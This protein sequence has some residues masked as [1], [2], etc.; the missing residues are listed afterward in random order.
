M[1]RLLATGVLIIGL[2][3]AAKAIWAADA[4]DAPPAAVAVPTSAP[5]TQPAAKVSDDARH[6]LDQI[7]E[8]YGKLHSLDLAGTIAAELQVEG[9]PPE[10]HTAAFTSSFVAPN[11]FRHE[12]K[13]D[14]LIGSTGT[15]L[16]TFQA[17][18]NAYTQAE[19]PKEKVASKDLPKSFANLLGMQDPSLML[20]IS[21][22]PA[23][24]L[25]TD[26]TD[27][28]K[29]DDTSVDGVSCPTLK[30]VQKDKT[31][32]L[33]AADPQTHFLREVRADLLAVLK[34]RREDL[35]K[36]VVT[37]SY[38]KAA[39][40]A[41]KD[42]QFAWSPP[43]GARD[44]DAMAAA[45]PMDDSKAS[46]LEGKAAPPFKLLSLEGKPVSLADANGKVV[47]LDFWATWCGPCREALPHLD[48]LYQELK[49]QG[50]VVYAIDQQEDKKDV[51]DYVTE[52]KLK[53]PFL[54]DTENKA[55]D[56][57]GADSLPTTVVIGKDGI[58]KKVFIGYGPTEPDELKKAVEAAMK[59]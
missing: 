18:A 37:V 12:V 4:E 43:P 45:R 36:A 58:V 22:N 34:Q 31:I 9:S 19:A 11:R 55:G 33:A 57:Y 54:L 41:V 49:D 23:E 32:V 47:V 5:S 21:K 30:L 46:A 56:Q 42:E 35:V 20:V 10:S 29:T 2:A 1:K 40:D 48:Q 39:P 8:A 25:L 24:E 17:D 53:L 28:T 27:A 14:V 50:L 44:A 59:G 52:A 38:S 26:V 51:Q 15:S 16:Y 13:D 7:S 3:L 6:L